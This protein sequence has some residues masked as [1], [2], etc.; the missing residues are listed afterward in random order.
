MASGFATALWCDR[1]PGNARLKEATT[2]SARCI[3][4]GTEPEEGPCVSCG[5]PSAFGTKLVFGRAY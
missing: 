1:D 4:F 2:A 5:E 3:P